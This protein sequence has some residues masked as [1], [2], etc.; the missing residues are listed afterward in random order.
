MRR[1]TVMV[2]VG[3]ILIVIII[4]RINASRELRVREIVALEEIALNLGEVSMSLDNIVELKAEIML[5]LQNH[6]PGWAWN[7]VGE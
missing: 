7:K 5:D 3:I 6:L 1:G 4:G 2:I